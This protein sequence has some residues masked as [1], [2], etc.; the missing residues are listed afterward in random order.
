MTADPLS[1]H[2]KNMQTI[3]CSKCGAAYTELNMNERT[4]LSILILQG[5]VVKWNKPICSKCN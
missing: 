2:I 5:W 1:L 3:K 4:F